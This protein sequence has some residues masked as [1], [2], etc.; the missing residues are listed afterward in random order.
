MQQSGT[1]F[2]K[3]VWEIL[4]TIPY[5]QTYSYKEVATLLNKNNASRAVGNAC[6]KNNLLILIPCHR[7]VGKHDLGGFALD[8]KIKQFLLDLEK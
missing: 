4:A 5:G 1:A 7:V 6:E 2:Q 3:S 8:L